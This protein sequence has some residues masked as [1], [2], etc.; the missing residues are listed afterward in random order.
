MIKPIPRIKLP[1]TAV[2]KAYLGNNGE[3]DT[4][5]TA[6][7]LSYVKIEDLKRFSYSN[8]GRELIGNA[9][10]FYDLVSSTGLTN[11]PI[12]NSKIEFNNREYR[13]VDLEILNADSSTPH[14]YEITLK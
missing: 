4:W 13:I 12:I 11:E 14:H 6:V 5:N 2:Y 9:I 10:M 3:G 7:T 8:N 1:N